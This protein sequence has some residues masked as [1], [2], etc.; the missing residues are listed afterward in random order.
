MQLGRCVVS[1]R[2]GGRHLTAGGGREKERERER[3]RKHC[4][5]ER[6][7]ENGCD[8]KILGLF[9]ISPSHMWLME[10]RGDWEHSPHA[11]FLPLPFKSPLSCGSQSTWHTPDIT[12]LSL[13]PHISRFVRQQHQWLPP[14]HIQVRSPKVNG[15]HSLPISHLMMNA[16]PFMR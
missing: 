4:V 2:P 1:A 14:S 5:C 6:E 8:E 12:R 9:R 15:S 13:S 16:G 7:R 10:G 3:E 11:H